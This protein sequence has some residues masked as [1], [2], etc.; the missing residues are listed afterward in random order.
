M[1]LLLLLLQ[2][3]SFVRAVLYDPEMRLSGG[4]VLY[5]DPCPTAVAEA[6]LLR[7]VLSLYS[8]RRLPG[9]LEKLS[10]EQVGRPVDVIVDVI[11]CSC[12]QCCQLSC[13]A[14]P[15]IQ[16]ARGTTADGVIDHQLMEPINQL[17]SHAAL[18]NTRQ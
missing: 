16:E 11:E 15:Q 4:G 6:S 7:G 10:A 17:I 12:C 1:L 3:C 2:V 9:A 13:G 14:S 18:D 8:S 5:C